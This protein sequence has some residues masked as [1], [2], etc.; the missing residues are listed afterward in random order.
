M[1]VAVC[2][3]TSSF[4][5]IRDTGRRALPAV[6]TALVGQ[7]FWV[8]L[9]AID[10]SLNPTTVL[11]VAGALPYALGIVLL[12]R[13]RAGSQQWQVQNRTG[14]LNPRFGEHFRL[15][16]GPQVEGASWRR[17]FQ[18]DMLIE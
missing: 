1:L 11:E 14:R 16:S 9:L 12:G 6:L 15:A 2:L 7:L 17:P 10:G 5:I 13:S 3:V 18:T 8:A 4:P